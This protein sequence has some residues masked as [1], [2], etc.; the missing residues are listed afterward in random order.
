MLR[1]NLFFTCVLVFLLFIVV[2]VSAEVKIS[3]RMNLHSAGR[4]PAFFDFSC[5]ISN[6]RN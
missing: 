2:D 5:N 4:E 1:A 6:E 3:G